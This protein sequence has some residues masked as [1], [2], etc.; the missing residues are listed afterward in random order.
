MRDSAAGITILLCIS[1]SAYRAY[2]QYCN[3][4]HGLQ[5]VFGVDEAEWRAEIPLSEILMFLLSRPK[6]TWK[7][8]FILR[9]MTSTAMCL[10]LVQIGKIMMFLR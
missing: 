6:H 8:V 1:S 9:T 5:N 4:W 2:V 3:A 10:S 7:K